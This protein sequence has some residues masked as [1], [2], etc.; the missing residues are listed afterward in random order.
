MKT[1]FI[2]YGGFDPNEINPDNGDFS[3]EV[4]KDA[5][6]NAKVLVVP[7]AKEVDRIVP[8]VE[9]VTRELNASKWQKN[10]FIE[11]AEEESFITQVASADV[12][13][14]QGGTTIKL[15]DTLKKF[16]NLGEYLKG[17][18]VAGDSAGGNA[19]CSF[20][21]TPRTD[22]ICKGLGILPVKMI[23]HYKEDYKNKFDTVEPDLETVLLKE[24]MHKVFYQVIRKDGHCER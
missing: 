11:I 7:F 19:L 12:V 24:Y 18:T 22:E 23:P 1:K 9:R 8:T 13:Y 16:L 10:I 5:P 20:F 2:L 17:K 6:E 21:Y 15:L 4:L 14:F 3:R